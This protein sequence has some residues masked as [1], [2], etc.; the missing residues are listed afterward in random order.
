MAEYLQMRSRPMRQNNLFDIPVDEGRRGLLL[1]IGRRD[2][3][4]SFVTPQF[5]LDAYQSAQIPKKALTGQYK[6]Q[7]DVLDAATQFG[8]DFG[9]LPA[10]GTAAIAKP[11]ANFLM[12]AGGVPPKQTKLTDPM[13]V[14]HNLRQ[15]AL[16]KAADRG[17]IPVPSMAISKVDNPLTNF[18]DISLLGDPSMAVPSATNPV[19][20]TDA[21][22]MRQ[23]Q[24]QIMPSKEAIDYAERQIKESGVYADPVDVASDMLLGTEA[25]YNGNTFLREKFLIEQGVDVDAIAE[26]NPEDFLYSRAINRLSEDYNTNNEFD[27]FLMKQR[28]EMQDKGFDYTE[29]FSLGYSNLGTPKYKE[30]NLENLVRAMKNKGAGAENPN[31]RGLSP[32]RG[33]IAEKFKNKSEID[34]SRSLLGNSESYEE[35]MFETREKFDEIINGINSEIGTSNDMSYDVLEDFIRGRSHP[36]TRPYIDEL[37]NK[38]KSEIE[39]FASELRSLPTEYFELKPNRAVSLSE[40]KGAIVPLN[41]PAQVLEE[42]EDAGIKN[43]KTYWDEEHRRDL[44]KE[45]GDQFFTVPNVPTPL[46]GLLSDDKPKTYAYDPRII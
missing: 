40:F 42:L 28:E 41:V 29:R 6:T 13:I 44:V 36:V 32:L 21:Y 15:G 16:M 10:L 33:S 22:T 12:S 43:I 35:L 7:G 14:M 5:L 20:K 8:F 3:E 38:S 45:F 30:A 27:N 2:G 1:P 9:M 31:A 24:A 18:G 46:T 39:K 37:S 34:K 4:F 17:G 11:A 26:K 19:Y 23:P 25:N